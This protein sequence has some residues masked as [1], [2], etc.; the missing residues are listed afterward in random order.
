MPLFRYFALLLCLPVSLTAQV[1]TTL[2]I[3]PEEVPETSGLELTGPNEVWTFND[4]G[5]AA[6]LYLCDTAGNLLRSLHLANAGN[7]DWEDIAQDDQ[8]NLYVGDIG[9]NANDA[10]NL[11]IYKIPPPATVTGDLVIPQVITF[12][13][14]DQ[15]AFPPP[16]DGLHF[17]CEALWWFQGNLYL[18]TKDR[19]EPFA[20]ET[21]LYRLPDTP[22]NH[23]AERVGTFV[24]GGDNA[25][26]NWITA[27]DVSPDGTKLALLSSDKVWLCYDFT[28]DDFFGG[29]QLRIDLPFAS[30]KEAICF[31][32]NDR[33]FIT[34]EEVGGLFGRR[35][36]ALDISGLVSRAPSPDQDAVRVYPNPTEGLLWFEGWA[37]GAR[38]VRVW[39]QA[40]RQWR[41]QWLDAHDPLD[42]SALPPGPYW[43]EYRQGA[44][45]RWELVLKR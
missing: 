12:A 7:R 36:Y 22:G 29:Q 15:T 9:N 43:L 21:R 33:L 19:S 10:T 34:D 1:F 25:L 16:A 37:P 28:G 13:Y 24:H 26:L 32:G 41:Q 27:G 40:G 44:Q 38:E 30:Q 35:L 17:D 14:E 6:T 2:T 3:L 5:G 45:R 4:S 23:L 8:G 20:G 18:S 42:L 31:V 11:R 39:D